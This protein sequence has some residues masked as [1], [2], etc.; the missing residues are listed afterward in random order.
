MCVWRE[1]EKERKRKIYLYLY[2]YLSLSLYIY[3]YIYIYRNST[4]FYLKNVLIFVPKK[5]SM[6]CNFC[7]CILAFINQPAHSHKFLNFEILRKRQ[8]LIC[9]KRFKGS[10]PKIILEIFSFPKY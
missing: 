6:S 7:M 2:T 8:Y 1:R 3:I 4:G 9:R 10:K 5:G